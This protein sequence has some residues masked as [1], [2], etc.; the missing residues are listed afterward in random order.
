MRILYA[1]AGEHLDILDH[2]PECHDF[3]LIDSQPLSTYG[4]S[5][6]QLSN[7]NNEFINNISNNL[8]SRGYNLDNASQTQNENR[9]YLTSTKIVFKSC[10]TTLS[11][12]VSTS[13]PNHMYSPTLQN[14]L[15]ECDTLLISGHFPPSQILNYI[16]KPFRFIGYSNTWYP[17][18][19]EINNLPD[20]YDI[21][22]D[23]SAI[24]GLDNNDKLVSEY[25]LVNNATGNKN[26]YTTYEEFYNGYKNIYH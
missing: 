6:P 17:T 19:E 3:I 23:I 25:I 1:G 9:K 20:S 2:F 11:Y 12:Y 21:I 16:K 4:Y 8:Y 5:N 14:H 15:R 13:L 10:D 24:G 22:R 26:T 7:Y 18:L